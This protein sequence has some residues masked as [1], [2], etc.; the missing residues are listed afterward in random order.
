MA[1]RNKFRKLVIGP[2]ETITRRNSLQGQ[3]VVGDYLDPLT[4]QRTL[5]FERPE[6]ASPVPSKPKVKRARKTKTNA[7]AQPGSAT[8]FPC[9][10]DPRG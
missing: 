8:A 4:N 7:S 3:V 5:L 9:T 6:L 1:S 10:E 2:S